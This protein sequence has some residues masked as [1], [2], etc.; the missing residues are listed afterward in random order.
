M[1]CSDYS[2]WWKFLEE[3]QLRDAAL[4]P[5]QDTMGM[6][7]FAT[8]VLLGMVNVPMYI[9]T[10]SIGVPLVVTIIIS[11][12]VLAA[13]TSI[14]QGMVLAALLFAG[15]IGPVLLLRRVQA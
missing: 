4:C 13:A 12:V 5:Y 15:G 14:F 9:K 10:D 6:P 7:L 11:G 8:L 1:A 2:V 3:M